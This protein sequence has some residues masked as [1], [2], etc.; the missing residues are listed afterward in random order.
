MAGPSARPAPRLEGWPQT[1]MNRCCEPFAEPFAALAR[2]LALPQ[3]A[4]LAL[5]G[6]LAVP[7]S[8]GGRAWH[9]AFAADGSMLPV[10][11]LLFNC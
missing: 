6:P 5:G 3:T 11:A 1:R 7:E 4:T 9:D 10:S 2:Q 8:D